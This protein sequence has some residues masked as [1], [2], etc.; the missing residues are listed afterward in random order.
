MKKKFKLRSILVAMMVMAI[1][2]SSISVFAASTDVEQTTEVS[3]I[4]TSNA[5]ARSNSFPYPSSQ[6]NTYV[7]SSSWKTVASSTTGFNCNVVVGGSVLGNY[8]MDVRML[9]KNGNVVWSE[10]NAFSTIGG[11]GGTRTFWCG[12]DIYYIQVK[13]HNGNGIAWA[14]PA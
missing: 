2:M 3:K 12:S 13:G 8:Y 4:S 6:S 1:G 11:N 5:N 10:E 7:S 14:Y 9:D